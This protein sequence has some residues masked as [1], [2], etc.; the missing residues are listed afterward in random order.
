MR[1]KLLITLIVIAGVAI[2]MS[3]CQWR[4]GSD[5][6][7]LEQKAVEK[8]VREPTDGVTSGILYGTDNTGPG[9]G[10]VFYYSASGFTMTDNNQVCHYLEAAPADMPSYLTW[11]SA[12][13][14]STRI[15]GT[16]KS[17]GTGRKN[18]AMILATDANA[19]A[20]KACSE[21]R[22]GGKSDWF[23]PSKN[24][25]NELHNGRAL[26]GNM[27]NSYY[28]S[29]SQYINNYYVVWHQ[30]FNYGSQDYSYKGGSHFVRAIRAF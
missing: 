18:T 23:L 8:N 1:K 4:L 15:N 13:Y 5:I 12:D 28:W 10:K 6:E 21:Y 3:T 19:P 11:A 24:E 2:L 22:G 30:Y 17:I 26:V 9:G 27:S 14:Y 20:A 16:G 7:M 25:L 29:S